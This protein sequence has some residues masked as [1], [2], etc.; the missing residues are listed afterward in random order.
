MVKPYKSFTTQ[1]KKLF[2]FLP[3]HFIINWHLDNKKWLQEIVPVDHRGKVMM[4][5][6]LW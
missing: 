2:S 1:N 3:H 6:Q 4:R 5:V